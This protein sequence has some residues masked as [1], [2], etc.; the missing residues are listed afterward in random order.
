ML[1]EEGFCSKEGKRILARI[2]RELK[3]GN[4]L[5]T[6]LSLLSLCLSLLI[7]FILHPH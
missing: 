4:S 5:E 3:L 7:Y 6:G 1:V 2:L